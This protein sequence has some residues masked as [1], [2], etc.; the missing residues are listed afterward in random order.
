MESFLN[1]KILEQKEYFK[2]T[3]VRTSFGYYCYAA[4]DVKRQSAMGVANI[5]LYPRFI[6]P[7][8]LLLR[9]RTQTVWFKE[10]LQSFFGNGF[11]G[12]LT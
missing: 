4:M 11:Y 7:T 10:W 1:E 12:N 9:K 6:H 8:C 5:G 3:K 2:K